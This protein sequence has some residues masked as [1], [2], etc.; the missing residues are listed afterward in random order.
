MI[1][2]REERT[3]PEFV[4]L[5]VIMAIMLR[6]IISE[7]YTLYT[8]ICAINSQQNRLARDIKKVNEGPGPGLEEEEIVNGEGDGKAG[9]GKLKS[10]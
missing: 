5:A 2:Q 10:S 9:D 1:D 3:W 8:T 4:V 7:L 6:Y